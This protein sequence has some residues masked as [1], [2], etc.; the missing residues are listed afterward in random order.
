[1]KTVQDDYKKIR[2]EFNSKALEAEKFLHKLRQERNKALKEAKEHG[3]KRR[4]VE[5][6]RKLQDVLDCPSDHT[7]ILFHV[8]KDNLSK[9][10]IKRKEKANKKFRQA[11][12][13]VKDVNSVLH[14]N[15][16]H[17]GGVGLV[18][19]TLDG[20]SQKQLKTLESLV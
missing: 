6:Q 12:E 11:V 18:P 10:M 15:N 20:L 16:L 17:K 2:D 9:D 14:R 7:N 5:K 8:F 13:D 19:Y 3:E 4:E 1:M